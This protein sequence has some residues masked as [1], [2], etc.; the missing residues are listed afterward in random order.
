VGGEKDSLGTRSRA[1]KTATQIWNSA[2]GVRKLDKSSIYGKNTSC[3]PPLAKKS[4]GDLAPNGGGGGR[5]ESRIRKRFSRD[6]R[7]K[8]Q[9]EKQGGGRDNERVNAAKHNGRRSGTQ[10]FS[11]TKHGKGKNAGCVRDGRVHLR[12]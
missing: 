6:W 10:F 5:W 9:S 7:E 4:R 1:Q 12:R 11:Q 8:Q 2:W 3:G